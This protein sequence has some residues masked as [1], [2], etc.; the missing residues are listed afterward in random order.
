[1]YVD[2]A[3][4]FGA[5]SQTPA[6]FQSLLPDE[7]RLDFIGRREFSLGL[8]LTFAAA[9]V[10]PAGGVERK[11]GFPQSLEQRR[12]FLGADFGVAPLAG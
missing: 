11:T 2:I 8:D 5:A 4:R 1:M 3:K 7:L 12:P 9:A 10:S 6:E